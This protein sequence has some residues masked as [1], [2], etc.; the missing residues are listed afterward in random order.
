M[1]AARDGWTGI[2]EVQVKENFI[3]FIF[4]LLFFST[5]FHN[6]LALLNTDALDIN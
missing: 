3:S 4:S 6:T 5:Y 1:I 2:T